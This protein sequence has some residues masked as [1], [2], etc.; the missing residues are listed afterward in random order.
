LKTTNASYAAGFYESEAIKGAEE[1]ANN[2][3]LLE[4]Q[5]ERKGWSNRSGNQGGYSDLPPPPKSS[6][7]P[8]IIALLEDGEYLQE[9]MLARPRQRL[10]CSQH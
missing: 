3:A 9:A 6:D 2:K 8:E 7:N 5:E 4:D 10:G 1:S